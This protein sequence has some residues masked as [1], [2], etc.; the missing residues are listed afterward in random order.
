MVHMPGTEMWTFNQFD[1]G[2]ES[3]KQIGINFG[4]P[5]DRRDSN[6]TLWLD[7]PSV[8]GASPNVPI[9]ITPSPRFFRL[10]PLRVHG[11][12]PTW[13]GASGMEGSGTIELELIPKPP[14]EFQVAV[15]HPLDDAEQ[16][17]DGKVRLNSSDLELIQDGDPQTVGVRFSSVP[18]PKDAKIRQ[19]YVQFKVDETTEEP[20]SLVIHGQASDN[21]GAV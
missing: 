5:G 1:V 7:Y 2:M 19:A 12:P 3:V 13:V 11:Q 18:V 10:H 9:E 8:G 6:G 4:A 21:P 15:T 17:A 20:T 14:L 16:D